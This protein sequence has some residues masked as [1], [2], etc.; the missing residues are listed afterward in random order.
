MMS[1]EQKTQTVDYP[2]ASTV[3]GALALAKTVGRAYAS[4]EKRDA[5]SK[6]KRTG[7]AVMAVVSALETGLLVDGQPKP[8]PESAMAKGDYGRL[9]G[10][11]SGSEVSYWITL[12]VAVQRVGMVPGDALWAV[13]A[14]GPKLGKRSEVA[15]AIRSAKNTGDIL[16]AIKAAGFDPVTGAKATTDTPG[17][18]RGRDG[19]GADGADSGEQTPVKPIDAAMAALDTLET[20]LRQP[21]VQGPEYDRI[22]ARMV[23][24]LAAEDKRRGVAPKATPATVASKARK[25]SKTPERKTA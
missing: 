15:K 9:Y 16:A 20:A 6:D 23:K 7:R 18:P 1:S 4:G 11:N 25:A 21:T 14:G 12:A 5:A 22:R 24:I 13:L 19:K 3:E 10:L 2:T 8:R 17:S